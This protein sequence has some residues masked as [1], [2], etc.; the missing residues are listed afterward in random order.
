MRESVM[1][2]NERM[3]ISALGVDTKCTIEGCVITG[4]T[5]HGVAQGQGALVRVSNN[6]VKDNK[7]KDIFGNIHHF[8]TDAHRAATQSTH[9]KSS[10]SSTANGDEQTPLVQGQGVAAVVKRKRT[11]IAVSALVIVA[12]VL[13]AVYVLVS[14]RMQHAGSLPRGAHRVSPAMNSLSPQDQTRSAAKRSWMRRQRCI[15]L[16]C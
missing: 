16:P 9:G 11:R 6:T 7:G 3:G 5:E 2:N 8:G 15:E 4:N 10:R 12:L 13:G 1:E 14:Y